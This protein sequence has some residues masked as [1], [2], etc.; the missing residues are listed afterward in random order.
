MKLSPQQQKA[1]DLIMSFKDTEE[2]SFVLAGYAGTGKSTTAKGIAKE[3]GETR[4]V[5]YTGKAANVLREM[6]NRAS[7]IHSLLYKLVES[8]DDTKPPR[9]ELN[10]NSVLSQVDLVVVDEYSMLPKEIID[11]LL[12][13]CKKLLFLGDPFQLPPVNGECTLKPDF[14]LE[15]IHRQALD[16]N[17]IRYATDIREGRH[18]SF[19]EHSDFVYWPKK[20][21]VPDEFDQ[22]DQVIVGYNETRKKWNNRFRQKLGFEGYA[23]PQ[24]G[25][26][27][28]CVKNNRE[29]G[30]FNGMIGE[31]KSDGIQCGFEEFKI[32]F[33]DKKDL[34]VWDGN[35]KDR[36][37]PPKG[38]NRGL[39]RFDFGY[40]ITAHKAQGS[41]WDNVLIYN[42][43]I[44]KDSLEKRRW[45]YTA[46]TRGKK[47]VSLV[48]P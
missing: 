2:K 38:A 30:L 25:D 48:E 7:T 1:Y 22:A 37:E 14:F 8:D 19:C 13:V 9:Y 39:D 42:Q 47:K 6:G 29:E 45:A 40:A 16:S 44:G 43:P 4:F 32:D 41:E 28:I 35:F 36:P 33:D 3:F 34:K 31:A 18:L 10:M 21:F 11:D 26:K 27:L 17:I 46:I 20:K 23:L 12:A 24:L 15:E 5:T